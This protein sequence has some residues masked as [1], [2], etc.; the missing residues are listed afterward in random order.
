[1]QVYQYAE[2]GEKLE[3]AK[4]KIIY[5]DLKEKKDVEAKAVYL[6]EQNCP[7]VILFY[8]NDGKFQC[9][10]PTL[11]HMFYRF[12]EKFEKQDIQEATGKDLGH[13]FKLS[14]YV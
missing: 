7:E 11:K 13:P 4:A 1:M 10:Q 3:V 14:K 12:K 5:N 8:H 6:A 9:G 2:L